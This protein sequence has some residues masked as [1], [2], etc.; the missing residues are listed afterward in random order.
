MPA[1]LRYENQLG[2]GRRRGPRPY[3]T[4]RF[5]RPT[6]NRPNWGS[7]PTSSASPT[8]S[9]P[10]IGT[11]S[12]TRAHQT[13]VTKRTCP[14]SARAFPRRARHQ[15]PP[16]LLLAGVSWTTWRGQAPASSTPQGTRKL[17][18]TVQRLEGIRQPPKQSRRRPRPHHPWK[19]LVGTP[20]R[21]VV[22]YQRRPAYISGSPPDR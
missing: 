17:Q 9:W 8:A 16:S 18:R 10:N 13:P 6:A 22:Y 2:P 15:P 3:C 5:L 19:P 4:G 7:W 14:C 11:L 20:D 1:E 21:T 12:K